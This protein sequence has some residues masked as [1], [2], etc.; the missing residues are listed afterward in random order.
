MQRQPA[1]FCG[2]RFVMHIGD[3]PTAPTGREVLRFHPC[4]SAHLT[5]R[6]PL[7]QTA[8]NPLRQNL[9]LAGLTD[10]ELG[11]LS[12]DLARVTLSAGT[13]ICDAGRRQEHAYFPTSAVVS[14]LC[15]TADGASAEMAVIGNEGV[16]GVPMLLGDDGSPHRL[17]V[18]GAGEAYCIRSARL[19]AEFARPGALQGMLLRYI[20]TLLTQTAQTAVCNRHHSVEEQLCRRLL[21]S[22]DR[23]GSNEVTVTHE[24]MANMLGV[25]REGVTIAASKLQRAGLINYHRG[26]ITIVDR[27]NLERL[28]CECYRVIK[29]QIDRLRPLRLSA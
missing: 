25:R 6:H 19:K 5:A 13:V 7:A 21:S 8:A 16:A 18:Q 12:A 10:R 3:R 11:H 29:Q 14:L 23:M 2:V 4:R 15:V 27:D 20:Q 17:M 22:I 26:H 24:G 9:L 28:A 1:V